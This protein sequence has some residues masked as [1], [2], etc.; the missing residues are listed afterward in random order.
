MWDVSAQVL[1]S[2]RI[3]SV[4]M[5]FSHGAPDPLAQSLGITI[6]H[7]SEFIENNSLLSFAVLH[8]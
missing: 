3:N 2:L 6:L 1:P 8:D 7:N 4:N 5:V